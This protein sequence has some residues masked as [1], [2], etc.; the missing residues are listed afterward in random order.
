MPGMARSF[1]VTFDAASPAALSRFWAEAL[2]YV[3]QPP[4][5][6]F[7]SWEDWLRE[8]GV[9][10][11]DWD[12]A[13]ALVDPAGEGP[14][15]FFQRVPEPKTA[16]NRVHLDVGVSG[17]PGRAVEERRPVIRAEAERLEALGAH[18]IEEIEELGGVWIVMADPEG[19]EFCVT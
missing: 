7:E 5:T 11:S 4:P 6:G 1:Q 19:N 16:K 15:L 14:R 10:E 12:S 2:G 17:G 3:L 18:R 9:P 13:S 8:R